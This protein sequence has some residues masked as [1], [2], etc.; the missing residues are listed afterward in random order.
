M[1]RVQI[2]P[3]STLNLISTSAFEELV[4]PPS[5]PSHTSVSIFGYDGST[6]RPIGKIRFKLQIGDL[7]SE[8]TVY[9]IKTP[10][11]TISFSDAPGYMRMV[12]FLQPYINPSSSLV[13]TARYIEYSQTKNLSMVKKST[14]QTLRCM[15]MKKKKRRRK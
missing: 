10:H 14:L 12:L 1:P 8:V 5:K 15:W 2:D 13:T 9:A 7:I 3:G 6:Q 11:A 4:I